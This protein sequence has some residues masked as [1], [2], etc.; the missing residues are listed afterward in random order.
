MSR[1]IRPNSSSPITF[2]QASR[3]A[4][5]SNAM[6]LWPGCRRELPG[7]TT[8]HFPAHA[9]FRSC[10]QTQGSQKQFETVLYLS[11]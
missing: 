3:P 10:G 7:A 4:S 11:E 2:I 5:L 8:Q 9:Y 1:S 6:L